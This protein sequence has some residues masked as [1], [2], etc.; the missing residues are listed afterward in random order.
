MV[1]SCLRTVCYCDPFSPQT[2][3]RYDG[4]GVLPGEQLILVVPYDLAD[5]DG[6]VCHVSEQQQPGQRLGVQQA[7]RSAVNAFLPARVLTDP[8]G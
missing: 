7:R 5:G 1:P 6:A 2:P 4:E 3:L 8:I